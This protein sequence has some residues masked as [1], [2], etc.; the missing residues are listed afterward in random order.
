MNTQVKAGVVYGGT[1]YHVSKQQIA[2]GID[3]IVATP[4]RLQ[5]LVERK[6]ISLSKIKY[7]VLDEADRMLD[8]G[9]EPQI[10]QI[11]QR[12]GMPRQRQTVMT[13]ATFPPDVQHLATDFLR[14]YVF[15]AIGR[16]GGAAKTIKQK[17]AWVEDENKTDFLYGLLLHQRNLGLTLVFVNTKDAARD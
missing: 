4:G 8:M 15:V 11:V 6:H 12:L 17:L 7:L 10:R 5:D 14:E 13:S 16:V 1:E 2:G 9:F 3:L